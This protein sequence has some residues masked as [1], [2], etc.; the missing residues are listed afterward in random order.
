MNV[1]DIILLI[2]FVPAIIVG[3][4]KGFIAQVF[5]IISIVAGVWLSFQFSELLSN[6]IG[7]WI[8]ASHALLQVIAFIIIL[9]LVI[10]A[11][12]ALSKLLEATIKIIL[13]GWLNKLLG[14]V[15]AI[16]K[17]VLII[18]LLLVAFDWINSEFGLVKKSVLDSSVLYRP[19]L[20]AADTIFPYFK[21]LLS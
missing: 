7:R 19:L 21:G 5:S 12:T 2:C 6:W 1:L 4:R 20:N 15:F 9:I 8:H 17:Y 11:F 10:L 3:I 14:V 13:L 16:L 18:G